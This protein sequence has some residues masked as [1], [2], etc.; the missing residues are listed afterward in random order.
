MTDE[1]RRQITH[2][3]REKSHVRCKD[4]CQ[5]G[6]HRGNVFSETDYYAIHNRV[7]QTLGKASVHVCIDC[8]DQAKEWSQIHDTDGLNYGKHYV[9]RCVPCHRKYDGWNEMISDVQRKRWANTSPEEKSAQARKMNQGKVE[10]R[11]R[12][13]ENE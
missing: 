13:S 11:K 1:D 10:K 2:A 7:A 6:R 12:G 4:G 5:C 8:G 3:A 9:A